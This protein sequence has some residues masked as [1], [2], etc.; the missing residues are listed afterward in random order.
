MDHE[1][2]KSYDNGSARNTKKR[3]KKKRKRQRKESQSQS[4]DDRDSAVEASAESTTVAAPAAA[5]SSSLLNSIFGQSTSSPS[6]P[7]LVDS[8]FGSSSLSSLSSTRAS[9]VKRTSPTLSNTSASLFNGKFERKIQPP[10]PSQKQQLKTH[11]VSSTSGFSSRESI[12]SKK[13][14]NDHRKEGPKGSLIDRSDYTK[15]KKDRHRRK[16]ENK[17]II[18]QRRQNSNHVILTNEIDFPS[19]FGKELG[20]DL[21]EDE[22][23]VEMSGAFKVHGLCVIRNVIDTEVLKDVVLPS[24]CKLQARVCDSLDRK[25][26]PWRIQNS[27]D[28]DDDN[29]DNGDNEESSPSMFRFRE[30]ASRCKGRM[31]V[32]LKDDTLPGSMKEKF[33][34]CIV[35][36]EII[37]SII[38]I[39]F[40][41]DDNI[42][43]VYSGLIFNWPGSSTQPWHQDGQPLFPESHNSVQIQA[44]VPSYAINVFVP[45][46]NEDGEIERGPTEFLAGS[47]LWS[48]ITEFDELSNPNKTVVGPS[49]NQGDVLMYDYRVCHRGTANLSQI[50]NDNPRRILYLMFSRPWFDDHINFDYTKSAKSLWD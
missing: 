22:K 25:N 36:N 47:H 50:E 15:E 34:K 38:R 19:A 23:I 37:R 8:I 6:P 1:D 26:I 44:G 10:P 5:Q 33:Q 13:K 41:G 35:E 18:Q 28:D 16:Q 27:G 24:V 17:K 7:L 3:K 12:I 21:P 11:A 49:L 20:A 31:D 32:V 4:D 2:S 39:L 30:A 40:G 48:S 14:R 46:S 29:D 43:L 45:L 9:G 42:K